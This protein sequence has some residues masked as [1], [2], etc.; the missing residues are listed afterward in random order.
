MTSGDPHHLARFSFYHL[1][2]LTIF[3]FFGYTRQKPRVP[4]CPLLATTLYCFASLLAEL[5][6]KFFFALLC[7]ACRIFQDKQQQN[8]PLLTLLDSESAELTCFIGNSHLLL[9]L[10]WRDIYLLVILIFRLVF[11]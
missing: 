1:C 6:F 10:K 2:T 11:T 3:E 8:R 7:D 4:F 9:G 5:P